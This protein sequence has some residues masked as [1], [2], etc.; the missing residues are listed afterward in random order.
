MVVVVEMKWG[1]RSPTDAGE[2][3]VVMW[4]QWHN[5]F[6]F[7]AIRAMAV[8]DIGGLVIWQEWHRQWQWWR[9]L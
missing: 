8:T 4:P 9:Y 2:W 6:S 1:W 7:P 3:M 5:R